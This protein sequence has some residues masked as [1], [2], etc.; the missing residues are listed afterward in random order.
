MSAPLQTV[1]GQPSWRLANGEVE[2]FVT[3]VGGTSGRSRSS[4]RGGP[5][6]PIT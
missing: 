5:C 4:W 2:S 3:E 1:L 6:S